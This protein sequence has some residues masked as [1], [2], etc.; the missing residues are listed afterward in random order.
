MPPWYVEKDIGIQHFKD[1]MSLDD[2]ETDVLERWWRAGTPEGD[3]AD[4][5]PPLEFD[6]DVLWVAGEP[7]LIVR[8]PPL[9]WGD[10]DDDVLWVAGR[11]TGRPPHGRG[12]VRRAP[13]DLEH[14]RPGRRTGRQTHQ[15]DLAGPRSRPRTGHFR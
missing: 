3:P 1:D 12:P 14:A 5:P 9:E 7:D 15:R 4:L 10:I 13:Y 6:D 2:R 8:F 11:G